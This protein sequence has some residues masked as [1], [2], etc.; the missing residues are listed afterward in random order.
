MISLR[1]STPALVRLD[2]KP[3][4]RS[5]ALRGLIETIARGEIPEDAEPRTRVQVS[6]R[7]DSV[8]VAQARTAAA[9]NQ[10]PL[11]LPEAIEALLLEG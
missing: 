4:G 7:V 9:A 11:D 6:A 8:L 5:A 3:E 2:A 10:P 1:I